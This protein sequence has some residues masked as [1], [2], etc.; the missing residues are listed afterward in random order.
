LSPTSLSSRVEGRKA[1]RDPR[2]D[3]EVAIELVRGA[4][5]DAGAPRR[6]GTAGNE[7]P[8]ASPSKVQAA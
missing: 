3:R 7:S 4:A 1:A 6:L 5:A 8:S 2:L